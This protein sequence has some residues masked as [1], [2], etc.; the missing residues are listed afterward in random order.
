M[1]IQDK[2]PNFFLKASDPQNNFCALLSLDFIE[3]V[4]VFLLFKYNL[5]ISQN[6][7]LHT[8]IH[9]LAGFMLFHNEKHETVFEHSYVSC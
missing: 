5:Y 1:F 7:F 4:F 3:T 9:H 2:T 6:T 8:V